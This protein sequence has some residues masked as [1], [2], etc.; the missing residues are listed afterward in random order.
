MSEKIPTPSTEFSKVSLQQDFAEG[1]SAGE[2]RKY[3]I[4]EAEE[5][6][7]AAKPFMDVAVELYEAQEDKELA[8]ENTNLNTLIDYAERRARLA[9]EKGKVRE[10]SDY[11]Q[12]ILDVYKA[13]AESDKVKLELGDTYLDIDS[14]DI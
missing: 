5:A 10:L 4:F 2:E 14:E 9:A 3:N 13:Q 7:Y 8:L 11:E 12:K 6:A 1:I